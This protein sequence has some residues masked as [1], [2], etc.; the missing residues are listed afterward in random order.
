M[1]GI[2]CINPCPT[3]CLD[4]LARVVKGHI[5]KNNQENKYQ[6]SHGNN[7]HQ[8]GYANPQLIEKNY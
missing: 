5:L 2:F 8:V 7:V 4:V 1:P 6:I 3:P